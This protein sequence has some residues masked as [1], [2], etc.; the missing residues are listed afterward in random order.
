MMCFHSVLGRLESP[1]DLAPAMISSVK[2]APTLYYFIW[3]LQAYAF[4]EAKNI[5]TPDGWDL[6]DNYGAP[7]PVSRSAAA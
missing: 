7:T 2:V 3:T 1:G 5:L 4:F 6:V